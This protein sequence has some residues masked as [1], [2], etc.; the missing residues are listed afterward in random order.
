MSSSDVKH[1]PYRTKKQVKGLSLSKF[2]QQ[3]HV[4]IMIIGNGNVGKTCLCTRLSQQRF[5][6]GSIDEYVPVTVDP[7]TQTVHFPSLS[8][9]HSDPF[10][11]ELIDTA[12]GEYYDTVREQTYA[13]VDLILVA[14]NCVDSNSLQNVSYTWLPEARKHAPQTPIILV[15][16]KIDL[17]HNQDILSRKMKI[18]SFE[19]GEELAKHSHCLT[20]LETSALRDEGCND[21][22]EICVKAIMLS[23]RTQSCLL[24]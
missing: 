10:T 13:Q 15:S 5:P 18:I 23:K 2:K 8:Q 20:F 22:L 7:C 4:K 24:Q 11:V 16:T 17:R 3:Q 19:E 14:Y 12:G 6:G 21:F 9:Q 1:A